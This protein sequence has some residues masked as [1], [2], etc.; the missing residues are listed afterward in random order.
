M[1]SGPNTVPG[2]VPLPSSG[3]V[4]ECIPSKEKKH[5]R[6]GWLYLFGNGVSTG[7]VTYLHMVI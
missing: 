1:P 2:T 5:H 6:G 3:E 7:M 4:E